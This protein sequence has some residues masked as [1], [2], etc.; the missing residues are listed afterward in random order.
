M[1]QTEYKEVL[2]W[3]WFIRLFAMKPTEAQRTETLVRVSG[4]CKYQ[5][6]TIDKT[7]PQQRFS[8]L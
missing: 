4:R 5:T 1:T 8:M 2:T 3:L 7:I 6:T